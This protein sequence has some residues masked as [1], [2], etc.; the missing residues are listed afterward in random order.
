MDQEPARKA[1]HISSDLCSPRR[2]LL[3]C[4]WVSACCLPHLA[5]AATG[6]DNR[7]ALIEKEG[8]VQTQHARDTSW[9][10]AHTNQVLITGDR[11]RTGERSRALLRLLDS[12]TLR[13]FELGD[14]SVEPLSGSEGKLSFSIAKGWAYFFHRDKPADI[15]IRT[16]TAVAAIRGTEFNI[17]VEESGRTVVTLLDGQVDLSNALGAV[18]LTNGEQGIVDPGKAPVKAPV[19]NTLNIIQWALYYPGIL[20]VDELELTVEEK[21][22]LAA[23]LTAYRSG[24]LTRALAS[25]PAGRQP[26][27][28]SE[29]VFLGALLLSVG[30]VEQ[31]DALF[32]AR[33]DDPVAVGER[34]TP[35]RLASAIRRMIAAVK[36]QPDA[37]PLDRTLPNLSATEWLAE[38]YVQQAHAQ[39]PAALSAARGATTRSPRFGFAWARV[40]ELEFSFGRTQQAL[41]ALDRSLDLA[42]QNAQAVTLRGFGL[43]AQNRIPAALEAFDRAIALDGALGNA[44]L[45]RGLCRIRKGKRSEGREDLQVATTLE[46]QRAIFRSYLGKAWN[47]IGDLKQ[48]ERELE[49][50]KKSDTKDPTAWLYSALLLQQN[51]RI[52]EALG[53]LEHSQELNDNRAVYRSRLM[54]DQDRAVRGANLANIYRDAGMADWGVREASKAVNADYANWSA[55]QFLADTYTSLLDPNVVNLRYETP[56]ATERLIANLLSPVG[57]ALLSPTVSQLEYSRF[58]D[59]D[60]FGASS[61]TEYQSRGAWSEI[62]SHSGR[63]AKTSYSAEAQHRFDPGWAPFTD[64]VETSIDLRMKN[65]LGARDDVFFEAS[66][67]D[68]RTG[69]LKQESREHFRAHDD[70]A[71]ILIAGW[72]RS[73][74]PQSHTLLLGGHLSSTYTESDPDYSLFIPGL[75]LTETN[76]VFDSVGD[77]YTSLRYRGQLSIESAELQHILDAGRHSTVWGLLGQVGQFETF[78]QQAT[79][80]PTE[81]HLTDGTRASTAPFDRSKLYAYD[82]WQALDSLQFTAGLALDAVH[83]PANYRAPPISDTMRTVSRLSPKAGLVWT[84]TSRTAFRI[85]QAQGITGAS[86]DQSFSLEPSQVAGMNQAFRSLIPESIA[87]ANAGVHLTITSAG[88]EQRLGNSTYWVGSLTRYESPLDRDVGVFTLKPIN[89]ASFKASTIFEQVKYHEDVLQMSVRHL[90]ADCLSVGGGYQLSQAHRSFNHP[91]ITDDVYFGDSVWKPH[92]SEKSLLNRLNLSVR[93]QSS[94]GYFAETEWRWLRQHN[95]GDLAYFPSSSFWQGDVL[96]GFRFAKRRGEVA[97]GILNVCDSFQPLAALSGVTGIPRERTFITRVKIAF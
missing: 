64:L 90:I 23:S 1:D 42:P 49:L 13:L 68:R 40:A 35:N 36:N 81:V 63:F 50:A 59:R 91:A 25:Y 96:A 21:A 38:S 27:S 84:P 54:L 26:Q 39:L 30:Q 11:L 61:Q 66:G 82:T 74:S 31:S 20:E 92:Q 79:A 43:A 19:I 44:W 45:G 18:Q 69:D 57:G 22:S 48:A 37:A 78:S 94:Q 17:A 52:N 14:Y 88:W 15:Q 4:A 93:F 60:G 95:Q 87:G 7:V 86:F 67:T 58:F 80:D 34:T 83:F 10:S 76:A 55:H 77:L 47:E 56:A 71:P 70:L 51:N 16:R 24:D 73:W 97:V 53:E 33:A 9:E 12:T 46:P 28:A 5:E 2:I 75:G 29:R 32:G 65:E 62:V 72:H 8:T 85:A 89:G 6:T 3:V 41:A